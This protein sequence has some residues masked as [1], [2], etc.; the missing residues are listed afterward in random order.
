MKINPIIVQKMNTLKEGYQNSLYYVIY[1]GPPNT[2]YDNYR[3]VVISGDETSIIRAIQAKTSIFRYIENPSDS[4]IAAEILNFGY[5]A[6]TDKYKGI[7]VID[8]SIV[9]INAKKLEDYP[10]NYFT[11]I[12]LEDIVSYNPDVY[13]FI[14]NKTGKMMIEA[15]KSNPEV[16]LDMEQNENNIIFA[17]NRCLQLKHYICL[18]IFCKICEHSWVNYIDYTKIIRGTGNEEIVEAL[19][20]KLGI[21]NKKITSGSLLCRIYN[22][23][24][25]LNSNKSYMIQRFIEKY[26]ESLTQDLCDEFFQCSYKNIR[27]IPH[28]Y[29]SDQMINFLISDLSYGNLWK[30]LHNNEDTKNK[31]N[32]CTYIEYIPKEFQTKEKVVSSLERN[33]KLF[34]YV[35]EDFITKEMIEK[36]MLFNVDFKIPNNFL[37]GEIVNYLLSKNLENIFNIPCEFIDSDT[38]NFFFKLQKGTDKER[39]YDIIKY[40]LSYGNLSDEKIKSFI[41]VRP[42][43]INSLSKNR[44]KDF[45]L[46]LIC[47][48]PYNLRLLTEEEK[49]ADDGLLKKIALVNEPRASKYV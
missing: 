13:E 48:N 23:I 19:L 33:I 35:S 1:N 39:R 30:Y 40:K 16:I 26:P 27:Y 6:N 8:I 38:M 15:L 37:N 22:S 47:S 43:L 21:L 7:K 41:K 4:V 25:D 24:S 2:L 11:E 31:F 5:F 29:Q 17:L 36:A 34:S 28:I 3:Y 10:D 44:R 14:K 9:K 32:E 20:I 45:L 49:N 12:E 46:T 18:S 42:N